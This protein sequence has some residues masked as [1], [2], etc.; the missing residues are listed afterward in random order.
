MVILMGCLV[1]LQWG[2]N[3]GTLNFLNLWQ[4]MSASKTFLL[5]G[6]VVILRTPIFKGIFKIGDRHNLTRYSSGKAA[7]L[8]PRCAIQTH[9]VALYLGVCPYL[10]RA[11]GYRIGEL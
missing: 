10:L 8:L 5:S 6:A 7:A 4:R 11:S 1:D 3:P 9:A 2:Q